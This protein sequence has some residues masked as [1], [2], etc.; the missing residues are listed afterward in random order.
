MTDKD[1]EE[2]LEMQLMEIEILQSIYSNENEFVIEDEEA[3]LDARE[4]IESENKIIRIQRQLGF[5]IKF[6]T[7][8]MK[9]VCGN[10]DKKID[11]EDNMNDNYY[12][13]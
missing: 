5:I 12:Q 9:N 6:N 3:M 11:E 8:I 4:F 2:C 13:V 7:D 1:F 10:A